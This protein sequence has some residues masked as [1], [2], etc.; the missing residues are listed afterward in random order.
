MVQPRKQDTFI[1]N[2][3][4][5]TPIL[6]R[7]NDPMAVQLKPFQASTSIESGSTKPVSLKEALSLLQTLCLDL[8]SMGCEI[9]IATRNSHFY[10]IGK[11]NT[12]I[13]TMNRGH[14]CIDGKPVS[15][16]TGKLQTEEK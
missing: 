15:L 16:D 1:G 2:G 9:S 3:H 12:G 6:A 4:I 7:E 13:L 11:I 10:I 14:I 8:R 5:K